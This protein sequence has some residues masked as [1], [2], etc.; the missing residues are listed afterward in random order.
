MLTKVVNPCKKCGTSDRRAS[1]H[2]RVCEKKYRAAWLAANREKSSAYS[3]T[4]NNANPDSRRATSNRRRVK[5]EASMGQLSKGLSEK[6]YRLQKGKCACCGKPLGIGYHMDHILPL[7]LN[8][9][10]TDENMQLLTAT[11]NLQKY[12]K[13]PV[14]FMQSR[15]FLL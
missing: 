11:C 5:Q 14:D 13:H 2:C 7:A 10:N 3:T 8:G 15:G 1:G 9:T 4:W 6:L 12:K